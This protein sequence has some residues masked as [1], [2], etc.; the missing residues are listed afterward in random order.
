MANT[1]IFALLALF[2]T[3]VVAQDASSTASADAATPSTLD[4][5]ILGCVTPAAVTAGCVSF[6][7]T[8]CVCTST[9]FQTLAGA[10]LAANCTAEDVTNAQAISAATCAAAGTAGGANASASASGSAA[11]SGASGSS[12]PPTPSTSGSAPAGSHSSAAGLAFSPQGVW[13]LAAAVVGL[14][15]GL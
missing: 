3:V 13:G 5:C 2:A 11:P 15:V 8:S 10:C 14:A 7:N 4:D 1:K 12:K 6:T 9:D